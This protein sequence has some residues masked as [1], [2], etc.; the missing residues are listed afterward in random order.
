MKLKKIDIVAIH[1]LM[2]S[3][4]SYI[5]RLPLAIC[6]EQ[7]ALEYVE[8]MHPSAQYLDIDSFDYSFTEVQHRYIDAARRDLDEAFSV[9][10]EVLRAKGYISSGDLKKLLVG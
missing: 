8:G 1:E 10:E 4:L 2:K 9:V 6:Q 3:Y 7:H 5:S